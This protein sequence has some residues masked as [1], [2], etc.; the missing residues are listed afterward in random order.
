MALAGVLI[1]IKSWELLKIWGKI[2]EIRFC[3]EAW[4]LKSSELDWPTCEQILSSLLRK[5]SSELVWC[6]QGEGVV[7]TSARYTSFPVITELSCPAQLQLQV[8]SIEAGGL[9]NH[10][11]WVTVSRRTLVES[12]FS[13]FSEIVMSLSH[14]LWREL[15]L[16]LHKGIWSNILVQNNLTMGQGHFPVILISGH[17]H[18]TD[19]QVVEVLQ[20][21]PS[22]SQ[23][24]QARLT[25]AHPVTFVLLFCVEEGS[26]LATS[27]S[28]SGLEWLPSHETPPGKCFPITLWECTEIICEGRALSL[29]Y[30]PQRSQVPTPPRSWAHPPPRAGFTLHRAG[31]TLHRAGFKL[32]RAGSHSSTRLQLLYVTWLLRNRHCKLTEKCQWPLK[33]VCWP[34]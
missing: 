3:G 27:V 33:T 26:K 9:I 22:L 19:S 18:Y 10:C 32:F 8:Q 30:T 11:S 1:L 15:N 25:E 21:T 4:A 34:N 13:L 12:F 20:A 14:I 23:G 5:K 31:F 2:T 16:M 29:V 7:L 6:L 17:S 28:A 24:V